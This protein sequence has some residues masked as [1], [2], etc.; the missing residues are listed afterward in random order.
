MLASSRPDA[1]LQGR[2][3]QFFQQ[4]HEG[5]PVYGAGVS[6]QQAGGATVSILGAIE[7]GIELDPQPRFQSVEAL[8]L[9]EQQTGAGALANALPE[10]VILQIPSGRYVLAYRAT[11]R[12]LRTYFLD[13]P[14]RVHRA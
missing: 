8:K 1:Q 4:Y 5:V 7:T 6:R 2:T 10:L 12:D 14:Q 3:Q 11:M 13:A 9:L